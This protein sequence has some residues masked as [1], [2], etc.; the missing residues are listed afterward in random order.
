[1]RERERERKKNG[2]ERVEKGKE[3]K[4]REKKI[5]EG[6]ARENKEGDE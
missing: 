1:M 5:G 6:G 2:W 4:T 3:W